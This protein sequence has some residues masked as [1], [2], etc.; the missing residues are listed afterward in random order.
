MLKKKAN[1]LRFS[2]H[3]KV[4]QII[5]NNNERSAPFFTKEEALNA[6]RQSSEVD[7]RITFNEFRSLSLQVIHEVNLPWKDKTSFVL[8]LSNKIFCADEVFFP[9]KAHLNVCS[10]CGVHGLIVTKTDFATPE[11]ST[12]EEGFDILEVLYD[13]GFI[14]DNEYSAIYKDIRKSKIPVDTNEFC[15]MTY[16]HSLN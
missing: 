16:Q 10:E 1:V 8:E 5:F 15:I 9:K 7:E 12:K 14:D 11:F 13:D 3:G 2:E 4:V 6:L